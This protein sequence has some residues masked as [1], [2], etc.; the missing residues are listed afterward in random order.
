MKTLL[1]V[2]LMATTAFAE[3]PVSL[4]GM[5]VHQNEYPLFS[6]GSLITVMSLRANHTYATFVRE[7]VLGSGELNEGEKTVRAADRGT[8]TY[9]KTGSASGTLTLNSET[10]WGVITKNLS[11][12]SDRSGQAYGP[13]HVVTDFT[14][15]SIDDAPMVNASARGTATASKPLILGFYVSERPRYVLVR[16][17]GPSLAPFNVPE[18][19]EDT[20]LE[21]VPSDPSQSGSTVSIPQNDDWENDYYHDIDEGAVS[22][23]T[24]V[25]AFMGAFPLPEGSKDA[26]SVLRFPPGAYTVVIRTKSE[27]PAEVLGEI[28]VVP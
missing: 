21:I 5:I 15:S 7:T 13:L 12:Y 18:A 27:T 2:G 1:L 14:L 6:P 28:Y 19:A 22:L 4:S 17:I 23:V 3:A 10:G 25:G 16:A 9:A 8:F 26:A 24:S 20:V 11:F